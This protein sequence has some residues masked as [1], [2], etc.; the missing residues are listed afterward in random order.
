[1]RRSK[2]K[3][4]Y[5]FFEPL[6]DEKGEQKVDI[7]EKGEWYVDP[8]DEPMP[9]FMDMREEIKKGTLGADEKFS[10]LTMKKFDH[11]PFEKLKKVYERYKKVGPGDADKVVCL[12]Q[13]EE[14]WQVISETVRE[15]E[16][17]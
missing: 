1:M 12:I 15:L 17:K 7:P 3:G 2:M 14:L 5:Y 11:D 6:V 8:Y 9:M 16:G 13:I 4:N 10:I